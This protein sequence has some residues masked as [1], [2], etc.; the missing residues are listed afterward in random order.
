MH[1]FALDTSGHCDSEITETQIAAEL[2]TALTNARLLCAA[3]VAGVR[4]RWHQVFLSSTTLRIFLISSEATA[5]SV[6]LVS[7]ASLNTDV[8]TNF[9]DSFIP[10][11]K[12]FYKTRLGWTTPNEVRRGTGGV[13]V[14]VAGLGDVLSMLPKVMRASLGHSVAGR[15]GT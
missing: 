14:G 13:G 8:L 10:A 15:S 7:T 3:V 5:S 1:Y 11:D 9:H 2:K 6:T 12:S 4:W